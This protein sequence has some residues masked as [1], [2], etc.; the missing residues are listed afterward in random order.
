MSET[1]SVVIFDE[2]QARE[3]FI[4]AMGHAKAI[5]MNGEQVAL[6]VGPAVDEISAKQRRFFHG[7]V[8]TQISEQVRVAGERYVTSI[9]KEYYRKLFLPDRWEMRKMPGA[10]RATPHR[11]RQSTEDLGVKGYSLHIDRVTAHAATEF[12]VEFDFDPSERNG[13]RYAAPRRSTKTEE[14][15]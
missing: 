11:V 7:P 10:K 12:G 2:G 1:L 6:S 3:I 13:V 15:P 14:H 4:G 5:L 8:L 9:W